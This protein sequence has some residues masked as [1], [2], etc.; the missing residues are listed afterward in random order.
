[1]CIISSTELKR[2]YGKYV[3]MAET[4]EIQVTKRGKVIFTIVPN[5]QKRLKDIET[6][7]G[8]LPC[9]ATIGKDPNERD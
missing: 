7:F 2:N 5:T 3:K 8:I 6:L 1:M 9:D 4:Q